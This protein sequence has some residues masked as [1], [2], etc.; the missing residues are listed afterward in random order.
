VSKIPFLLAEDAAIKLKLQGM[1]VTDLE[2]HNNA[3]TGKGKF[4]NGLRPVKCRF[5]LPE[6]DI[7]SLEFPLAVIELERIT[8]AEDR[9]IQGGRNLLPY[10]P[11]GNPNWW[12]NASSYNVADSPYMLADWPVPYYLDY[13]ISVYSRLARDHHLPLISRMMQADIFPARNGYLTIPQDNTSRYLTVQGGPETEY[14]TYDTGVGDQSQKRLFV[15]VWNIRIT[16]EIVGPI[17]ILTPGQG[18]P[19]VSEIDFDL[20]CY[21]SIEPLDGLEV[22]QMFGIAGS[23]ASFAWN[24]AST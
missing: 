16:T 22:S 23:G 14:Q 1:T 12:G 6:D 24:V 20:E 13:K 2:A 11:E 4:P 5:R 9:A 10:P 8:F 19:R 17:T 18:Y 7:V 15:A 3:G 21:R